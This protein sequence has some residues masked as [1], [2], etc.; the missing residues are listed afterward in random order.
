[1]AHAAERHEPFKQRSAQTLPL[2]VRTYRD[3]KF[4]AR[5]VSIL[6]RAYFA[7]NFARSI[8]GLYRC[9]Q[10]LLSFMIDLGHMVALGMRYVVDA[11]AKTEAEIV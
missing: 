2:E 3:G 9:D 8:D 7:D 11:I 4:G 1:M 10:G 5:A 6:T